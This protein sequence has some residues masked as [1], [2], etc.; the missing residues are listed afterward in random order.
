MVKKKKQAQITHILYIL[1]LYSDTP[2]KQVKAIEGS[3][4]ITTII[5]TL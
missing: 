4:L 3:K 2:L 1:S 5:S